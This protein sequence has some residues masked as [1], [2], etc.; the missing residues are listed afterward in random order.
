MREEPARGSTTG[1]A[2]QGGVRPES[3]PVYAPPAIVWEEDYESVSIGLTCVKFEG[4][5]ECLPGP[6]ST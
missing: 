4:A 5:N 3:P 6:I 1:A 2:G